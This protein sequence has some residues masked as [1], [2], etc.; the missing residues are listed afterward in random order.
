MLFVCTG[1]ICRSPAAE[2]LFRARIGTAPIVASSA[3]TSGLSGWDMDAPSAR[4]LRAFGVDPSAHVARRMTRE[5]VA[6]A[7]LVLTADTDHRSIVVTSKFGYVPGLLRV[8]D[9]IR[10]KLKR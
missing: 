4:A 9:W 7:D 10:E 3:G 2:F 1:N 5:M 8:T 6:A